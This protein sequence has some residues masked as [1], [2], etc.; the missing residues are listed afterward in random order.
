MLGIQI[1]ANT[2][3]RKETSN[4]TEI[5]SINDLLH[6][7]THLD[8]NK[9]CTRHSPKVIIRYLSKTKPNNRSTNYNF[10]PFLP[11]HKFFLFLLLNAHRNDLMEQTNES[12]GLSSSFN[13]NFGKVDH[14]S[15]M[16]NTTFD[17]DIF[18]SYA[19]RDVNITGTDDANKLINRTEC[20]RLVDEKLPNKN[21]SEIIEQTNLNKVVNNSINLKIVNDDG[22]KMTTASSNYKREKIL[23][24]S[25]NM[26]ELPYKNEE[27][28]TPSINDKLI[29]ISSKV[30]ELSKNDDLPLNTE[31]ISKIFKN[32]SD[33]F[34]ELPSKLKDISSK[35]KE[36][37][38]QIPDKFQEMMMEENNNTSKVESVGIGKESITVCNK[39]EKLLPLVKEVT[40]TVPKTT[41]NM[42]IVIAPY[43]QIFNNTS[44][45]S[46]I[47]L[48]EEKSN[49]SQI[50]NL[51]TEK[52]D[53]FIE[54]NTS[55]SKI[56]HLDN[57]SID[58]ENI[59]DRSKNKSLLNL[60]KG[61]IDLIENFT[62]S[63]ATLVNFNKRNRRSHSNETAI[64]N[65][66]DNSDSSANYFTKDNVQ[67]G[68]AIKSRVFIKKED[69][70]ED[71]KD[72]FLIVDEDLEENIS[73]RFSDDEL[74]TEKIDNLV[75]TEMDRMLK[76]MFN[77]M[78]NEVRRE[79]YSNK[80]SPEIQKKNQQH[81]IKVTLP[82]VICKYLK[83][84]CIE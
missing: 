8:I 19:K 44:N 59:S 37:F 84:F 18:G 64:T 51:L 25:T 32:I 14:I 78:N 29:N 63:K 27:I 33:K 28:I 49:S 66:E 20:T 74:T 57:H 50:E 75:E 40:T 11:F 58:T 2:N 65:Q 38:E 72:F 4:N 1:S 42:S 43:V 68:E 10:D 52:E 60:Q 16:K 83:L 81:L 30:E 7:N 73:K 3:S 67:D 53:T 24:N 61:P 17:E 35:V 15:A 34:K 41:S 80:Q 46:E 26:S 54:I 36:K 12:N 9:N 21:S 23:L 70:I 55:T 48:E 79:F 31:G 13:N 22:M 6:N 76:P 82:T 5:G 71:N 39:N 62:I 45:I 69:I 56:V 77:G 47:I